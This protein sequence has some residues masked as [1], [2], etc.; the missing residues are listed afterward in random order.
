MNF[1][2]RLCQRCGA[3]AMPGE[4]CACPDAHELRRSVY[5]S[6]RWRSYTRPIVLQRDDGT[7]QSCGAPGTVV[8][9]VLPI[10][11]LVALGADPFDPAECQLLCAACS[12]RKDGWGRRSSDRAG[13]MPV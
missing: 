1:Q 2:G 11:T 9:H 12:G 6:H 13:T 8:D 10:T 3:L 4:T 7:C 5:D